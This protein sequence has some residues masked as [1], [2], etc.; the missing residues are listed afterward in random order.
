MKKARFLCVLLTLVMVF[1]LCTSSFASAYASDVEDVTDAVAEAE[2]AAIAE[3]EAA[4]AAAAAA[5]AEAAKVNDSIDVDETAKETADDIEKNV[6]MEETAIVE[7]NAKEGITGADKAL[8]AA[9]ILIVLGCTVIICSNKKIKS[10][11]K[12]KAKAGR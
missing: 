1:S 10:G 11:K 6:D 3:A 5:A 7:E 9:V 8:I 12:G 4:A 2:A